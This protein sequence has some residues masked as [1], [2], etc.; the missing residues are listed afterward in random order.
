[1][2]FDPNMLDQLAERL[3]AVVPEGMRHVQKDLERNFRA[4]LQSALGRLDLV[5]RDEFDAQAAVLART[6][7]R[8]EQ[9]S[10]RL[11]DIET[12]L[13]VAASPS[14]AGSSTRKKKSSKTPPSATE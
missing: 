1:M 4:V 10:G 3:S 7:E 6:R 12:D 13:G 5:T 2:K 14:S 9:L 11:R 8:L